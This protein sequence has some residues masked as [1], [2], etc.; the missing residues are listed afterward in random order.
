MLRVALCLTLLAAPALAADADN[1]IPLHRNIELKVGQSMIVHGFR[2][3]CGKRPTNVDPN[4]TR[5]TKLGILRNG[6][7]GVT[8]SRTCGGWTPAV[9]V[10]FEARKPGRE[11]ITVAGEEIR[12]R[13]R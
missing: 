3:E 12:V 11:T 6:N 13:V 2:G 9:E 7:W 4:R 5:A 8:R 10:I 1:Q